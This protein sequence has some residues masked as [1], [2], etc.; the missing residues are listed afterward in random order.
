LP[1]GKRPVRSPH[2]KPAHCRT[3]H[4]SDGHRHHPEPDFG[5]WRL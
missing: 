4:P 1:T 5:G 2:Q 3:N